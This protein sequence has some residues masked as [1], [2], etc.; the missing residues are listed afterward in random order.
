MACSAMLG[1]Q[2]QQGGRKTKRSKHSKKTQK[3]TQKKGK[4]KWQ[5]LVMSVYRELKRKNPN[6]KLGDAMREASRRKKRE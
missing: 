3:K 6:V 1:G 5:E 4:G 2:K